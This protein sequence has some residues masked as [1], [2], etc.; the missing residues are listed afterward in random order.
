MKAFTD[1]IGS[2]EYHTLQSPK[3]APAER[4]SQD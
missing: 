1:F 3:V 4:P 2:F